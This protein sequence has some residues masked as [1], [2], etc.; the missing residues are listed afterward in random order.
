MTPSSRISVS[1]YHHQQRTP[2]ENTSSGLGSQYIGL[3]SVV[4]AQ[5]GLGESL[6]QRSFSSR[7]PMHLTVHKSLP[8]SPI[9]QRCEVAGFILRL[10]GLLGHP[11]QP[12]KKTHHSKYPS[13]FRNFVESISNSPLL[14]PIYLPAS[15]AMATS[16][17]ATAFNVLTSSIAQRG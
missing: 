3:N 17:P 1:I 12:S 13:T 11:Q 4:H 10:P 6:T 16:L 7:I 5:S 2:R 8:D 9:G 15:S 14:R